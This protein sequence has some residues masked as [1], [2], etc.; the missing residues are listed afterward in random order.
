MQKMMNS[1]FFIVV[2][3]WL[4]PTRRTWPNPMKLCC[5]KGSMEA[6][7][8]EP[9]VLVLS[10]V[11]SFRLPLCQ[12]A[13]CH[14]KLRW[15][16]CWQ[17]HLAPGGLTQFRC[18]H[19]LHFCHLADLWRRPSRKRNLLPRGHSKSTL[20]VDK[21]ISNKKFPASSM[22]WLQVTCE[23]SHIHHRRK[24]Y[25][26]TKTAKPSSQHPKGF[27]SVQDAMSW[28]KVFFEEV[29]QCVW[30]K[31]RVVQAE[32]LELDYNHMLQWCW[33]CWNGEVEKVV[34]L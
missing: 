5:K 31:S 19:Q 7:I 3:W 2:L 17:H 16:K 12:G 23:L 28:S 18:K 27:K 14:W 13:L 26:K 29:D 30:R 11:A 25:P 21:L 8:V 32:E 1:V 34:W 10:L 22:F 6:N 33:M 20:E 24:C 4:K 9:Q 15:V